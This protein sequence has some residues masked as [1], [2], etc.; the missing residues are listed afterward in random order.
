VDA[1][2]GDGGAP[3]EADGGILAVLHPNGAP[4]APAACSPDPSLDPVWVQ[5]FSF[6]FIFLNSLEKL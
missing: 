4:A 2:A 6:L 3:Q 5:A 1:H